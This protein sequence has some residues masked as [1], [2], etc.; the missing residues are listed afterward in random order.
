MATFFIS[1][2]P[3]AVTWVQ[4]QGVHIDYFLPHLV[5]EQAQA[6]D[7]VVGNLPLHLAAELQQRGIRYLHLTLTVP[8]KWRGQELT[9]AQLQ[10]CQASIREFS[11]HCSEGDTTWPCND[12]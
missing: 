1:R 10:D 4:Q 2:H 3:G 11:I 7:C 9:A 8:E 12:I 6:G 5:I